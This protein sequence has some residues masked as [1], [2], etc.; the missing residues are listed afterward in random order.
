MIKR[1][2]KFLLPLFVIYT[3]PAAAE[4]TAKSPL[5]GERVAPR[6]GCGEFTV[7]LSRPSRWVGPGHLKTLALRGSRIRPPHRKQLLSFFRKQP[8]CVPQP[9]CLCFRL[10]FLR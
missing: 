8:G 5:P 3:T 2:Q 4:G 1:K 6:A 10:L 9:G 7:S